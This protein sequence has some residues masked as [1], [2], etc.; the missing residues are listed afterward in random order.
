[1]GRTIVRAPDRHWFILEA[2]HVLFLAGGISNCP[3]WQKQVIEY[4]PH[5]SMW[6]LNPRR[7]NFD[8]T[9]PDMEREQIEWEYDH[10]H[11]STMILFW[12]PKETLCPIALYELGSWIHTRKPI[13]LGCHPEYARRRDLEIQTRLV[14]PDFEISYDLGE[15]CS[16]VLEHVA[17][18]N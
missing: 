1:M 8:V 17:I 9:N 13:F 5:S 18:G 6:I 4:L 2:K 15:L 14:R 16:R 3:D 7:N 12:F 10:L 11:R